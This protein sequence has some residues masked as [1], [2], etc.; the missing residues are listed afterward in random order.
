VGASSARSQDQTRQLTGR[1]LDADDNAPVPGAAVTVVNSAV[2]ATTSDSG[3]FRLRVPTGAL[4]VNV[5]RIGYRAVS[6]PVAADQGDLTV[7]TSR[8]VLHLEAQVVTGVATTISSQNAANAVAVVSTEQVSGIPAPTLENSLQG[9]IPGAVIEQNNGGAPGGGMQ[10]QIRGITSINSNASPLYVIDGVI[11]NNETVNSGLNSVTAA[12]PVPN[13]QDPEDNTP[14]RMADINPNDIES[15][16]VLK[17]ASAA[18]IYGSKAASGV[19]V[20]TTKKGVAGAPQWSLSGR[21]GTFTPS[22][23]LNLRQF[24]TYASAN[25]W[26]QNDLHQASNLPAAMYTGNHDFQNELFGGGK[27]SG[28]G[29]LSVRGVS[30]GTNYFVSLLDKYDGGIMQNTGYSKQSAR[31]NLTQ[32]FSSTLTASTNLF[33]QHSVTTRGV[34]GND[35]VGI[36]PYNVFSV[37]PQFFNLDQRGPDGQWV[38]NPFGFANP[39]A[40]AALIQTPTT[41]S[42][43]I[44]GGNVS[45]RPLST[46]TQSLQIA[47]IGGA[48]IAGQNDRVYAP[49]GL[50]V[51]QHNPLP[52]TAN[53]NQANTQY[54]NFSLNLVHHF[55]GIP[56][57]DATTSVGLSQDDRQ[58]QNPDLVGQNLPPGI[59]SPVYGQVQ[60]AFEYRYETRSQ[61]IYG[62]EQ[63][64]TLAQRLTLTAGLTADRNSNNGDFNK[65][66]MYPKFAASYRVPQ[67]VGF[68]NDF[69]LR[70]AYGRSGT[71]PTYGFNFPN[72]QNYFAALDGGRQALVV[73]FNPNP[74]IAFEQDDPHIQPETNTEIET[75]FDATMV[76]SRAQF[77]AT[78]Y[79]KRV[80]NL[81][82][83][84]ATPASSGINT[85]IFNGGQFTNQGIEL[86]FQASPVQMANGF[87][88]IVN[89]SFFRNYSRVDALPIAPFTVLPEFGGFFGSYRVQVGRSV[90]EIVNT[91]ILGPGGNPIQVGDAQPAFVASLGN[92]FTWHRLRLYGLVDWYRGGNVSNLTNAYYD[93]GPLLLADTAASLQRVTQVNGGLAPYVETATFV[94]VRE[95]TLS[96]DLPDRWLQTIGGG[97]VRSARLSASGR[98]LFSTFRYSGLDPEVSNF[99]NTNITRGQDVTPYP[100]ARS[101]FLSVDLGL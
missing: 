26:W 20:I 65:Y 39:F 1:V 93:F 69:K 19:V 99:G 90:S 77:S 11:V 67:F 42:R 33:Y 80:S 55:T 8:D 56:S 45:W 12:G 64:L 85:D 91:G 71:A 29:D 36:S 74:N 72:A 23:T 96:Y 89:T 58:L 94:K 63:L 75:G 68:V 35:N 73:G 92:A 46:E 98:N 21:G 57:V 15:I 78:V 16:E 28:E 47:L 100:P 37:T 84:A 43:F 40:D 87:T 60:T 88:W 22:N 51:E 86:A 32:T 14:N 6:V 59:S 52:G 62:Q 5:R 70:A 24:P 101:F 95:L 34:T 31:S 48:D 83:L 82:M 44:G 2:G 25:A 9:K 3:T 54:E 41:V 13:A 49:P 66:F 97:R 18:A 79:Q 81:V 76:N 7:R 53:I 30:G 27:P 17:G 4:T 50:Q 61:S 38:T 10:V